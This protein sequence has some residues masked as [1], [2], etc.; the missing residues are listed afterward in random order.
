MKFELYYHSFVFL[1]FLQSFS[2]IPQFDKIPCEFNFAVV[3]FNKLCM[4][5]NS[6][7]KVHYLL[8]FFLVFFQGISGK[9]IDSFNFCVGFISQFLLNFIHMKIYRL[10]TVRH[11]IKIGGS[12]YFVR[13]QHMDI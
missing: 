6:W 8:G 3:E 2:C 1:P 10:K 11:K 5:L 4:D 7:F 9:V 12:S 13:S